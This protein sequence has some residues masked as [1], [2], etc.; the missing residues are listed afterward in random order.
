MAGRKPIF[1]FLPPRVTAWRQMANR[2]SS[3]K[4][5]MAGAAAGAVLLVVLAFF[6]IQEWQLVSLR[7]R[8]GS[9]SVKVRELEQ[10]QDQIRQYRPWY[11]D[12]VRGLTILRQ[13]TEAFPEEGVVSAKTLEIR[14]LNTVTCTG[15]ARDNSSWLKTLERLRAS[16]GVSDLK[17]NQVRG[18]SP[19]QFT[20]DFHW[21]EGG[22]Q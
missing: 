21:S 13:V 1:N 15:M 6:G 2:Y 20:F 7:S 3:G 10:I 16:A 12:S 5:R 11:D 19:M 17:V 22:A 8:W 9:M 14:E 4:L 18:K